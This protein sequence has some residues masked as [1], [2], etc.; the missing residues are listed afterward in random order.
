MTKRVLFFVFFCL[1]YLCVFS[2]IFAKT[3]KQSKNTQQDTQKLEA[4][5][6][7]D[8]QDSWQILS[9]QEENKKY[10]QHYTIEI[11]V[12]DHKQKDYVRERIVETQDA[13]TQIKLL[14]RLTRGEYRYRVISYDLINRPQT[15]SN[16]QEFSI[17]KAQSPQITNITS[18][19][20]GGDTVYLEEANDGIFTVTGHNLYAP[21][22]QNQGQQDK[23]QEQNLYATE[24]LLVGHNKTLTPVVLETDEKGHKIKLQF[25]M[26]DLGLGEYHLVATDKSGLKSSVDESAKND[27]T[28]KYKKWLDF[29]ISLGYACPITLGDSTFLD[30]TDIKAWVQS[31]YIRASLL[32]IKRSFGYLGVGL[33]GTYSRAKSTLDFYDIES[34]LITA[35]FNF[36]YQYAFRHSRRQTFTFE[37]HIGAGL[38]SIRDLAFSFANG[39]TSEALNSTNPSVQVGLVLQAYLTRKLFLECGA[40]YVMAF[41]SDMSLSFVTPTAGLGWQF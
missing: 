32:P 36:I 29:D 22:S 8:I 11:Q 35:H 6:T 23:T 24:Y 28:V 25:D 13:S 33:F 40:D 1:L 27:I 18:S 16:W 5:S 3:K 19:V 17:I 7:P 37:A 39:F 14:P 15:T 38:T 34:T 10:V 9:W 2:G 20:E 31:G 21:Q 12:Y 30:Y 26:D 41:L 4:N